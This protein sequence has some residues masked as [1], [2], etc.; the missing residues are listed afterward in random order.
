MIGQS[1]HPAFEE[2]PLDRILDPCPCDFI[3][4]WKDLFQT[5]ALHLFFLPPGQPFGLRI[6][7]RDAALPVRG[8]HPVPNAVQGGA[9]FFLRR[10]PASFS[11]EE[12]LKEH[13]LAPV[14][15]EGC[16]RNR[17]QNSQPHH[18]RHRPAERSSF[19]IN[20]TAVHLGHHR[21]LRARHRHDFGQHRRAAIIH[22]LK[23]AG[24]SQGGL[25]GRDVRMGQRKAESKG[26]RRVK[27]KGIQKKGRI[28]IATD[29]QSLGALAGNRPGLDQGIQEFIGVHLQHQGCHRHILAVEDRGNKIQVNI[30]AFRAA[31]Q[32]ADLCGAVGDYQNGKLA[33]LPVERG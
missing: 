12:I 7:V 15:A 27:T 9:D 19:G 29:Q 14:K 17:H 8:D 3:N 31:D 5:P 24:D 6:E 22:A 18:Q 4:D 11:L 1:Y 2:Y 32:I 23:F 21:P 30:S 25:N 13:P 26:G 28:A 33:G 16:Q 10:A 20:F